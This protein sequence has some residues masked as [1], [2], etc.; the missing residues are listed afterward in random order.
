MLGTS[1]K[2]S[3]LN[4]K[5]VFLPKSKNPALADCDLV[6]SFSVNTIFLLRTC[7]TDSFS[8][9]ALVKELPK[10]K[11]AVGFLRKGNPP[12]FDDSRSTS[13]VQLS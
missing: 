5:W 4:G 6:E 8:S 12:T 10:I 9:C 1:H 13:I 2:G 11:A 7:L 3:S